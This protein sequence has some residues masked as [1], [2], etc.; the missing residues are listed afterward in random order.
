MQFGNDE[1]FLQALSVP[2]VS[3]N[4]F[5]CHSLDCFMCS[6]FCT[7]KARNH[8]HVVL[9]KGHAAELVEAC[10]IKMVRE[11]QALIKP[12]PLCARVFLLGPNKVAFRTDT[13]SS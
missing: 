6:C 11:N 13:V 3:A 2:S 5:L 12:Y 9:V 4:L 1:G 10:T 8:V 7:H